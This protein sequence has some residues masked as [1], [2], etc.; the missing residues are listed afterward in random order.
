MGALKI[1][2]I[3]ALFSG[4]HYAWTVFRRLTKAR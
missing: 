2:I 3:E 4:C 1:A